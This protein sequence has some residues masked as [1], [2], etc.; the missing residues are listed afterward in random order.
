[1]L[2][3]II[4]KVR[5]EIKITQDELEKLLGVKRA[6]VSKLKNIGNNF[7]SFWNID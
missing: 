6:Q 4:C 7:E 5:L 1:M 3:G 2:D